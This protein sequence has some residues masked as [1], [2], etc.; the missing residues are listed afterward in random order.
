M[1]DVD[2]ISRQYLETLNITIDNKEYTIDTYNLRFRYDNKMFL[3][4]YYERFP[5]E[6][7]DI[8]NDDTDDHHPLR[9]IWPTSCHET[10]NSQNGILPGNDRGTRWSIGKY[11]EKVRIDYL[12]INIL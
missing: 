7:I 1:F 2:I 4:T 5:G 10:L 6:T 12:V 11:L 3:M 8:L 9:S